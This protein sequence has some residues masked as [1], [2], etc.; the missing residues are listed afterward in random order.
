MKNSFEL[1]E[2]Q[3]IEKTKNINSEIDLF[4]LIVFFLI[5]FEN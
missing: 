5:V 2:T 3:P 4:C 1:K